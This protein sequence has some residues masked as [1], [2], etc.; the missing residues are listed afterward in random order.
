MGDFLLLDV[1]FFVH[2]NVYIAWHAWLICI[3]LVCI[4]GSSGTATPVFCLTV[5]CS[6]M[7]IDTA[8]LASVV[9]LGTAVVMWRETDG[10]T[11]RDLAVQ[12]LYPAG[13]PV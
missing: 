10:Q 6:V 3:F 13:Y 11:F 5:A 12:L 2:Y 9:A 8:V 1:L 7:Y 4:F